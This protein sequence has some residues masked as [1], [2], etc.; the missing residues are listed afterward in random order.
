MYE[1]NSSIPSFEY[2][3]FVSN[4]KHMVTKYYDKVR[5][6]WKRDHWNLLYHLSDEDASLF[7]LN[8]TLPGLN[9][10]TDTAFAKTLVHPNQISFMSRQMRSVLQ[11]HRSLFFN[12]DIDS[13]SSICTDWTVIIRQCFDNFNTADITNVDMLFELLVHI[14]QMYVNDECEFSVAQGIISL[15]RVPFEQIG[16]IGIPVWIL[17]LMQ[18]FV[19]EYLMWWVNNASIAMEHS[20]NNRYLVH[21]AR[22][23][24]EMPVTSYIPEAVATF[25]ASRDITLESQPEV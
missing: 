14:E 16:N 8:W 21:L 7:L 2:Q 15:N 6:Y 4:A 12:S 25:F 13:C 23:L 18:D 3:I 20:T 5:L 19:I 24:N 1:P 11:K 10:F 22:Y 9:Q 17:V